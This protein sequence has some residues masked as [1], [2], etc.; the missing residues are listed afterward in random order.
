MCHTLKRPKPGLL[1]KHSSSM[2]MDYPQTE[3]TGEGDG[4]KNREQTKPSM[5]YCNRVTLWSHQ[6]TQE[7]LPHVPLLVDS[8]CSSPWNYKACMQRKI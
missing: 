4:E 3:L 8:W 1:L 2:S 6:Q 5:T 7:L